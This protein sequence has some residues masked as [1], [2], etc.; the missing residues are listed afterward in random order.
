MLLI[1]NLTLKPFSDILSIIIMINDQ[2]YSFSGI[3]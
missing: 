3:R 2:L 1:L